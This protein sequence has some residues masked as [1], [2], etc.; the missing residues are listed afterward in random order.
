MDIK[1][2]SDRG[3]WSLL[4]YKHDNS[5]CTPAREFDDH[6]SPLQG[7]SQLPS[8]T[9]LSPGTLTRESQANEDRTGTCTEKLELAGMCPLPWSHT[10]HDSK[11]STAQGER[12]WSSQEVSVGHQY[13]AINIRGGGSCL[14]I[15]V[16]VDQ[17]FENG[18]RR[19]GVHFS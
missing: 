1:T 13:W 5:C 11:P 12:F 10:S 19:K 2:Q 6:S 8:P 14:A 9:Q 15:C 3:S 16:R 7:D 17:L 18:P 4:S